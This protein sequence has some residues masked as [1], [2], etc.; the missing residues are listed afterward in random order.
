MKLLRLL[1]KIDWSDLLNR[2]V[3]ERRGDKGKKSKRS[4]RLKP[5]GS[6]DLGTLDSGDSKCGFALGA[7]ADGGRAQGVQV[8]REV[9]GEGLL[10]GFG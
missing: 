9:F 8:G 6:R 10:G 7:G 3:V 1:L 2:H 4:S 5:T